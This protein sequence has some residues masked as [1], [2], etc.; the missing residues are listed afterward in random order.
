[1]DLTTDPRGLLSLYN[2]AHM[3]VP[4]ET[5]LDDA[6]AF[7]R[8]HLELVIGKVRSPMAEQVSRALEIPRPRFARRLEAMHYITEYEQED[9]HDTAMLELAKLDFNI[10]R[11]FHLKELM[12]LSL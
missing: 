7:A 1:M 5:A 11:S 9:A 2:A 8:G 10:A 6:I 12:S 4:G 3:A